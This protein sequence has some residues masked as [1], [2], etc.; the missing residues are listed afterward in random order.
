MRYLE[1]HRP[2]AHGSRRSGARKSASGAMAGN[3]KDRKIFSKLT[4]P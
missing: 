1:S 2:A 4:R 3:S